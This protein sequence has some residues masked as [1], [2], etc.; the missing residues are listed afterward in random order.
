MSLA[1]P[2]PAGLARRGPHYLADFD[3]MWAGQVASWARD[4][5]E[6]FWLAPKTIP[7]LDAMKV[8]AWPGAGDSPLLFYQDDRATPVGYLEL[9]PM[10]VDSGHY[11]LGHCVVDPLQRGTGVGREMILTTLELAFRQKRAR[12]ISLVVFPENAPAVACYRRCG[13]LTAG[14][15]IKFF[16]VT[17][18]QHR[19]IQMTIDAPRFLSLPPTE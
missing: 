14:E 9:N 7:P 17:G 16:P 15:Q 19:M 10:P 3:R 5:A 1:P 8:L 12:R 13:F 11:W 2:T 4:P 6:L 18:Q